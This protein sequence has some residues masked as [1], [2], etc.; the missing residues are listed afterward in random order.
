MKP[1]LTADLL[2]ERLHYDPETGDFVWM[3]HFHQ[4][5]VGSI[6]GSL[7][8]QGYR[9]ISVNKKLYKANRLAWLYMTGEW[10][11]L[12]IDHKNGIRYDDRWENLRLASASQNCMNRKLRAD[13]RIGLKGVHEDP[14]GP[15]SKYQANIMLKGK[16][17]SLGYF[18]SPSKAH[19]A[20]V[21]AANNFFKEFSSAG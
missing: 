18:S 20:Y 15:V 16:S 6:A 3:R 13:N 8:S 21:A 7:N 19:E 17:V 1:T 11:K 12:L 4:Y 10:P 9:Y 2:K 5:L 14:R